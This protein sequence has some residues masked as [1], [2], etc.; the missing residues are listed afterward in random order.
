MADQVETE[1]KISDSYSFVNIADL[2]D[3]LIDITRYA[4]HDTL[5]A[6]TKNV[7]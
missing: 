2:N 6:V 7:L 3:P 5:I 1:I 4:S